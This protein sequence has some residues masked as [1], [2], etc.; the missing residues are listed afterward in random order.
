MPCRPKEISVEAERGAVQADKDAWADKDAV[1]AEIMQSKPREVVPAGK[2][3]VPAQAGPLEADE[4][5][6]PLRPVLRPVKLQGRARWRG[7]TRHGTA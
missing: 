4:P 7:G 2:Y 1:E 5:P 3:A 6:A